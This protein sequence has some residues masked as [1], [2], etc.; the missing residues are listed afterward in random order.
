MPFIYIF[1][2][3]PLGTFLIL[4]ST[5]SCLNLLELLWK[6]LPPPSLKRLEKV[7]R[8]THRFGT[9]IC[10]AFGERCSASRKWASHD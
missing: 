10:C 9:Y 3:S 5:F 7:G 1:K 4:L 8:M 2:N 6:A